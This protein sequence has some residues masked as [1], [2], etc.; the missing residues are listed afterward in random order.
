MPH[1][2]QNAPVS[3]DRFAVEL[4]EA[5]DKQERIEENERGQDGQ[6]RKMRKLRNHGAAQAFAGVHQRID[7]HN[8]L[9]NWKVRQRAPRIVSTAEKIMGATTRLN[10]SPMCVC[11]TMQPSAKPPV[12][13]NRATS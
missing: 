13:E 9:K 4:A 1:R 11:C 7:E 10:I 12:A 3:A 8:F 2:P 5:R 6:E